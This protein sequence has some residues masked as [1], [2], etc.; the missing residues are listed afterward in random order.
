[1][2]TSDYSETVELAVL[3]VNPFPLVNWWWGHK[4]TCTI[5]SVSHVPPA[6]IVS[7]PGT[8]FTTSTAACSVNTTDPQHS[9]TAIWVHFRPTHYCLTRRCVSPAVCEQQDVC[10]HFSPYSLSPETEWISTT[11]PSLSAVL[12]GPFCPTGILQPSTSNP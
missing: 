8:A 4:A 10:L 2:T 3:A 12:P 9:S 5:S 11:T 1:M 7:S 6:G